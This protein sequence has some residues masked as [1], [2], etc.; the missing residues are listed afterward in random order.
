MTVGWVI[1]NGPPFWGGLNVPLA[2]RGGGGQP[3][4]G[5]LCRRVPCRNLDGHG[6]FSSSRSPGRAAP[7]KSECVLVVYF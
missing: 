4:P 5:S 1:S 6:L 3:E 2:G 7:A